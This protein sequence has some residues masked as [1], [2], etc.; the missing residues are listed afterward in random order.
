MELDQEQLQKIK[1]LRDDFAYRVKYTLRIKDKEGKLVPFEINDVQEYI[2]KELEKQKAETGRVRAIILKG[3]KQGCSSLIAGRFFDR[4]MR[5][6]GIES[7][8]LAHREDTVQ[9]LY[10]IVSRFHDTYPNYQIK[11][12]DENIIF[13]QE[14]VQKNANRFF[15]KNN[16]GYGVGTA[17]KGEI[18]RGF[19]IQ[20]LHLS[21][22]AF[23]ENGDKISSSIMEAVP[24][25]EGTEIIVES[26]ANGIGGLFHSMVMKARLDQGSYKLIFIPWFWQK[27]Y[28]KPFPDNF[29]ITNEELAYKIKYNLEDSQIYW[30][31]K[32]I[33]DS[34]DGVQQF[35]REYPATVEEA[36]D[37]SGDDSYFDPEDIE[38]AMTNPDIPPG[39]HKVLCGLDI[40]GDGVNADR[41]VFCLRAGRHQFKTITF[42]RMKTEE[43]VLAAKEIIRAY[44]VSKIFV[45]KGFNPAVCE[46][47]ER[48][49]PSKTIGVF[50][51][52]G[53]DNPLKFK[54]KRGEMIWRVNM[55]LKNRPVKM[56]NSESMKKEL[57]AIR[58]KEK[59]E[60]H[61]K[62]EFHSK[63]EIKELLG[64]S[65]DEFDSL[66]LTFA[67]YVE[68]YD[69]IDL[70]EM[71]EDDVHQS[72]GCS[73][74][75]Y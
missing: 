56:V 63:K 64:I 17:G 45:D 41:I 69:D 70:S 13:K 27:E 29:R 53:A 34:D 48:D 54:N 7:F 51:G 19:T 38:T 50:F 32:K 14:I 12:G 39:K 10:D 30:R 26:T 43:I 58:R 68:D 47:L 6:D 60:E 57:L 31:R 61:E 1:R 49:F 62:I 52:G 72:H 37:T 8:I 74:T 33:E 46:F 59:R 2:T 16:S 71:E 18:G 22:A 44:K 67:F 20:Q 36:F 35:R 21:E 23:Y 5:E 55:W 9:T 40:A 4:M 24:D 11:D 28:R 15:F 65:P 42:H 73:I 3:R 75:G 66:A 25:A